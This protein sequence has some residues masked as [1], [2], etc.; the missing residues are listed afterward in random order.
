M[1]D[2]AKAT[3]T[4]KSQPLADPLLQIVLTWVGAF[5]VGWPLVQIAGARGVSVLFLYVF[6]I[7]GGLIVLLFFVSRSLRGS[8]PPATTD[9]SVTDGP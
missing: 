6:V 7:W 4:R 5:L 2:I 1:T 8:T 3:G 9:D